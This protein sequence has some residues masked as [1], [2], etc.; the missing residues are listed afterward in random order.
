MN[1]WIVG[2]LTVVGVVGVFVA[3]VIC[4][5]WL[6]LTEEAKRNKERARKVLKDFEKYMDVDK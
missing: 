2:V 1:T 6:M 5:A 4:G 3:G